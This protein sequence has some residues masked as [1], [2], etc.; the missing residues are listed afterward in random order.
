MYLYLYLRTCNLVNTIIAEFMHIMWIISY[1][2]IPLIYY[3][4]ESNSYS[5]NSSSSFSYPLWT[6]Y[7]IRSISA[8]RSSNIRISILTIFCTF[9]FRLSNLL[10]TSS[11]YFYTIATSLAFTEFEY[12]IFLNS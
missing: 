2:F 1:G 7:I 11:S 8:R 5:I 4:V 12:F 3:L 9:N 10:T 6:I